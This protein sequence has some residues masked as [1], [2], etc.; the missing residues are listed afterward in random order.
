MSLVVKKNIY[1]DK[2]ILK[3]DKKYDHLP[4]FSFLN[5]SD[6][7][8]TSNKI[9]FRG[10]LKKFCENFVSTSYYPLNGYTQTSTLVMFDYSLKN[11]S[12]IYTAPL[13]FPHKCLE[14]FSSFSKS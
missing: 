6:S 9:F 10:R 5:L 1:G 11:M 7:F 8:L 3:L 14:E 4:R 2:Y 13:V 12:K